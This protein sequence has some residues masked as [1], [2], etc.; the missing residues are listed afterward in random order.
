MNS[1]N[2][3]QGIE[4]IL[5][6]SKVTAKSFSGFSVGCCINEEML[7]VTNLSLENNMPAIQLNAPL[8]TFALMVTGV[9]SRNGSKLFSKLKL[10]TDNLPLQQQNQ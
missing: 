5:E 1:G 6:H 10:V 8:V 7:S 2:S 3:I 9:F 4:T